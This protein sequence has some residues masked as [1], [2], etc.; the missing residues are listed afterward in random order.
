MIQ[1]IE[2]NREAVT[3]LCHR[4]RVRRLEVFGSAVG[5]GFDPASSDLDFLV[6]FEDLRD[7]EY[8]DTYFGLLEGLRALFRCEVDLVVHSAVKNPYFRES[9]DRS[10]TLL[11]AA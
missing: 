11:Y 9:I 5:E 3:R 8:A 1:L 4:Y 7:N 10:R 6:E 2:D